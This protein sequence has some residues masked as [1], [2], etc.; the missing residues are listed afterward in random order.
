M[1]SGLVIIITIII[2]IRGEEK[3]VE[4]GCDTAPLQKGVN[5]QPS[6]VLPNDTTVNSKAVEDRG[7]LRYI[8]KYLVQ[9]CTRH[10]VSKERTT[11]VCIS[12]ARV[13]T[14]DKCVEILKEHEQKKQKEKE[15]KEKKKF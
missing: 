11:T 14:G 10:K 7:E 2:I 1:G 6:N 12:G 5:A 4:V 13:L 3:S 9:N 15:E 8:S